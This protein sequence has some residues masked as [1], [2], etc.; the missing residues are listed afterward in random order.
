M[1]VSSEIGTMLSSSLLACDDAPRLAAELKRGGLNV[2]ARGGFVR[3]CPDAL[4]TDSEFDEAA[5]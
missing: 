2:D 1:Y 5:D 4:N 3:L